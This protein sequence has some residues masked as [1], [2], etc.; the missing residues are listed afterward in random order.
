[1]HVI[2]K[3]EI[4]ISVYD[5]GQIHEKLSLYRPINSDSAG[6]KEIYYPDGSLQCKGEYKNGLRNGLWECYWTNGEVKWRAEYSGGIENGE[7][8]CVYQDGTWRLYNSRMGVLNG[9]T[10]E[11]NVDKKKSFLRNWTIQYWFRR[12]CL[13]L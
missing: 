13:V 11:Y 3:N 9:P 12:R 1:M 8:Y 5:D 10:E 4:I 7:V 6:V 2:R